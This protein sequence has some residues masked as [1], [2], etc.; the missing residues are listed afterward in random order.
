MKEMYEQAVA[1]SEGKPSTKRDQDIVMSEK[2]RLIKERFE[3]GEVGHSD[4][5]GEEDKKGK[6]L[7]TEDMSVFEAG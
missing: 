4:S 3:R 7:D 5:E 1:D 6:N 2:S